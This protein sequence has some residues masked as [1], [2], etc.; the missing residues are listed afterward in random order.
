[1]LDERCNGEFSVP[2]ACSVDVYD[3][4]RVVLVLRLTPGGHLDGTA[5]G[6][7]PGPEGKVQPVIHLCWAT[8]MQ[9]KANHTV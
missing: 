5:P 6:T 1:M 4:C 8:T 9:R 2:E 3:P 7:A